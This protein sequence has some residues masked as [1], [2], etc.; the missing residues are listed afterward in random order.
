MVERKL[1]EPLRKAAFLDRDGVLNELRPDS[2]SG[3]PES[4]LRAQD[5][6]LIPGAAEAA[7]R[8]RSVGFALF[9]VSNQ[10]AAA[11]GSVSL[12]Q[13]EDVHARVLELMAAAGAPIEDSRLCFHH[14]LGVVPELAGPCGC[15]KP[16]PGMLLDL[17]AEFDLDLA[18][19]WMIGDTDT[20]VAAGHAAGCRTI[21]IEHAPS[22]HKRSGRAAPDLT[23]DNLLD[24]SERLR[25][26]E[27]G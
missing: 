24:A 5:V 6:A 18:S 14:P 9:V 4:P 1:S 23:A 2:V 13:L 22:A 21:L 26:L 16:E 15:R 25:V 27:L 19:S 10:P 11:K 3:A 20:D 8:L 7:A 12:E 17:A